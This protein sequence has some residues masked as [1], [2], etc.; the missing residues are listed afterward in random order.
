MT[1]AATRPYLLRVVPKPGLVRTVGLSVLVVAVPVFGV[2]SF[3][4]VHNGNWWIG[5]V[6]AVVTLLACLFIYLRYR[7]T[8]I[9]V[10]DLAVEERGFWGARNSFA[11]A[12]ASAVDFVHTVSPTSH[13]PVPQLIVR[14][15]DDRCLLRMRGAFWTADAM[16]QIAGHLE[17]VATAHTEP[18]TAA[19]FHERYPGAAYWIEHRP[20]MRGAAIA[21]LTI[22]VLALIFALSAFIG[23]PVTR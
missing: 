13:E 20:I 15:T 9:V 3:L 18:L 19:E 6:G 16:R 10:T 8:S 21:V 2:L 7:G 11:T 23:V 12:D 22:V 17:P 1:D 5:A 14:G 4:G